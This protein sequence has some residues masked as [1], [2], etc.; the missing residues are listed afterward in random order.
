[1]KKVILILSIVVVLLCA[2]TVFIACDNNAADP[3]KTLPD[4]ILVPPEPP[5]LY[6]LHI[7]AN[8]GWF[9]DSR[10]SGNKVDITYTTLE[11]LNLDYTPRRIGYKSIGFGMSVDATTPLSDAELLAL[12]DDATIY[13][14]WEAVPPVE[15]ELDYT[16][17]LNE[18]YNAQVQN[19]LIPEAMFLMDSSVEEVSLEGIATVKH[20]TFKYYVEDEHGNTT[21]VED[22]KH[23]KIVNNNEYFKIE[24]YGEDMCVP[25]YA[26]ISF[27]KKYKTTVKYLLDSESSEYGPLLDYMRKDPVTILKTEEIFTCEPLVLDYPGDFGAVEFVRY[28]DVYEMRC[29]DI[30]NPPADISLESNPNYIYQYLPFSEVIV[31]V[32]PIYRY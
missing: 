8:E 20:G 22:P 29:E 4:P 31:V 28:G 1:M 11:G 27:H 24:A 9:K 5:T 6:T 30:A 16:G 17:T 25:E 15:I 7:D 13:V 12:E 23:A 26:R 32:N 2:L 14:I 19:T 10:A 21:E 18:Q 3:T